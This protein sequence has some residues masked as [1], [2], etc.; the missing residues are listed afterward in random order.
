[1]RILQFYLIYAIQIFR[2]DDSGQRKRKSSIDP[3]FHSSVILSLLH[4]SIPIPSPNSTG[5]VLADAQRT[6]RSLAANAEHAN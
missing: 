4:N 1:M 3:L 6:L 5:A 2:S